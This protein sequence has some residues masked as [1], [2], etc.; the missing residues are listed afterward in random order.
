MKIL[1]LYAGIGGNRKL[2][3]GHEVTAVEFDEEIAKAYQDRYP[4]D[5]VITGDAVQYLL[6]NYLNFDFIWA[7]PPCQSHTVVKRSQYTNES[8][9]AVLPDMTLWQIIAFMQL[10]GRKCK[11][12]VENVIPYYTP[13]I[14]PTVELDRH[15]Y[16]SNFN[17][18]KTFIE[19]DYIIKDVTIKDSEIDLSKYKI[20]NKR[21]V[22]RNQ[23]NGVLGL[24]ILSQSQNKSYDVKM[25]GLF[26]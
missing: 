3:E 15:L 10:H 21:Q 12:V 16:W 25:E 26:A 14:K 18:S 1:N 2:W 5:K 13:L 7:S 19:K 4:D 24:H 17:I 20:A 11:W 23:V 8:Y 22:I 9:N 6:D